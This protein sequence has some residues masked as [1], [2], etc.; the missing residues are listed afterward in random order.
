MEILNPSLSVT[1]ICGSGLTSMHAPLICLL[2]FDI[3]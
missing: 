1:T 2:Q 3:V